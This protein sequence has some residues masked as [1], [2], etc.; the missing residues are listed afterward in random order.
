MK[1]FTLTVEARSYGLCTHVLRSHK[2]ALVLL[3]DEYE[4]ELDEDGTPPDPG[5]EGCPEDVEDWS[6]EEHELALPRGMEL[7]IKI[8]R[9]KRTAYFP[10]SIRVAISKLKDA[11]I[12]LITTEAWHAVEKVKRAIKSAQ[13]ALRHAEGMKSRRGM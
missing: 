12:A 10:S 9:G 6:I 5:S 11:E 3:V 13:G 8:K 2:E 1:V 7:P 4:V